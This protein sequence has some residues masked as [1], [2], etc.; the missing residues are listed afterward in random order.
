MWAFTKA[1]T[2]TNAT[3]RRNRARFAPALDVLEQRELLSTLT[4][5][6]AQDSG[7]GSLRD[8][9]AIA[10]SGDTIVFDSDLI[11]QTITLTG[12][13][14]ASTGKDLTID[15][16]GSGALTVSGNDTSGIFQ[17][18]ADPSSPGDPIDV[19]ISGLT[20]RDGNAPIQ[21]G[22]IDSNGASL[23]IDDVIFRDN[24]T[25]DPNFGLGGAVN[26]FG[27][28][29]D[30]DPLVT[31]SITDSQF[32]NN[33]TPGIG[34]AFQSYFVDVTVAG[35]VF[36]DNTASLGAAITAGSGSLEITDSSFA[37]N[38]GG[39]A[40]ATFAGSGPL[41]NYFVTISGS[42]FTEN[43]GSRGGA[44]A[45][46]NTSLTVTDSTFTRNVARDPMFAEGGAIYSIFGQVSIDGSRFEGNRA[47]GVQTAFGGAVRLDGGQDNRITDTVFVDNEASG[48]NANGGAVFAT[49]SGNFGL[50]A[51]SL[52]LS[53]LTFE[54]NRAFGVAIP[55]FNGAAI[56]GALYMLIEGPISLTDSQFVGNAALG[57]DDIAGSQGGRAWG[58]AVYAG[59][60]GFGAATLT[61]RDT[62]F[63][64]NL[65]RSGDSKVTGGLSE[66][67]ALYLFGPTTITGGTFAGNSAVSGAGGVGAFSVVGAY[68]GA[69]RGG[70]SSSID[71]TSFIGNSA[72][73][74][75]GVAGNDGGLAMGGAI[76]FAGGP[77]T[78]ALFVGNT[79]VG[80]R[81]GDAI[82]SGTGGKGG[83]AFGGA[84]E[85]FGGTVSN[86]TFLANS[87]LGGRGGKG[88]GAGTGGAGGVGIGGAIS[89]GQFG[90]GT[91]DVSDSLFSF[92]QAIGGKGGSGKNAG[93]EGR[94]LGGGIA[95]VSGTAV[96]RRTKFFKNKASTSGNNVYGPYTS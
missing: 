65:A 67:G 80:G 79:A 57:A 71:G 1:M 29:T 49:N 24:K 14:I 11:G 18:S 21:G 85:Y 43:T 50:P 86:S 4:V 60:S 56:G 62:N 58:G 15:G 45:N 78:N 81:G 94:G 54:N 33:S 17:F 26:V 22:A 93:A 34:G 6:N 91:L 28:P 19:A 87:A 96:I 74:S 8:T 16:P 59:A 42:T 64:A 72:I 10:A 20:L 2:R 68:G 3:T 36:E 48:G 39:S 63:L 66:G 70:S 89:F 40:V 69:I 13:A 51:P 9:V 44:I 92:N 61:I 30:G 31:V 5:L 41:E 77:I 90:P 46:G 25:A 47:E 32:L 38:T 52:T 84:L 83:D 76:A 7:P 53:G 88:R 35:S 95:I 37:R 23:V 55:G 75:D 27:F 82:G 12:G 73:G